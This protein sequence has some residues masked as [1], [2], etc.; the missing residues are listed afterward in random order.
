MTLAI[1]PGTLKGSVVAPPSKSYTHRAFFLGLLSHGT[2]R[3]LD[4]LLSED[5]RATLDAVAALGARVER[6]AVVDITSDGNART[7]ENVIDCL[8]SGTTLRLLSAIAALAPGASV[9]TGDASLRKRPMK[10][11]VDALAAL[12]V[13]AESTRDNGCAPVIVRGPLRG[14]TATLP[15]DVSSQFVS[16]LL[17]AGTRTA[18][19]IDVHIQGELK[20]RPY[21]DITREMV[22]D[23]G[24]RIEEP[25]RGHF[26]APGGQTL[27]AR[28]Y[29]VPGDYST[30]AFPLC[31]GA[32]AGEVT[33]KNLPLRSAQGDRAIVAHL[34]AFGADIKAHGADITAKRADLRGIRVDLSDTPD[35]FPVLCAVAAHARGET[36]LSGAKHLRFKESDRIAVMVAN[37]K[38]LGV[39]CEEREDGA[40]IRG[41][42]VHAA[43]GLVTE[44]D[45]RI[46]MA[47]AVCALRAE[48]P[49]ELDDHDAYRVSYPTFVEDFQCLGVRMEVGA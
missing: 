1:H 37:L 6:G 38:R 29:R 34:Q 26:H 44:G 12:G 28:E 33:V 19:G 24:G 32:L 4:P 35:A 17:L 18:K 10:P 16:A 27:K 21:V 25:T 7:P 45:H 41:G 14:G 13:R 48:G 47:L 5:P 23:F 8:N 46:L 20:S 40:V 43:K 11:L 3:V 22:E 30:A 42:K 31:A 49:L 36:V 15:G 9:L 2:T 39:D